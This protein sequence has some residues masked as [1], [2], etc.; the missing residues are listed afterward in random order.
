MAPEARNKF[1]APMFEPK[2]FWKH[3]KSTVL[4]YLRD[5]WDFSAPLSVLAIRAFSPLTPSI[6]VTPVPIGAERFQFCCYRF[7]Q[8]YPLFPLWKFYTEMSKCLSMQLCNHLDTQPVK[9]FMRW[10]SYAMYTKFGMLQVRENEIS[11]CKWSGGSAVWTLV[12]S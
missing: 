1:G 9:N 7:Y 6:V 8:S 2:V 10:E 11:L 5:C 4:K 12:V 3:T